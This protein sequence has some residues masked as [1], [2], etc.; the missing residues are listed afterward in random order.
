[1]NKRRK[2]LKRKIISLLINLF[3]WM[4]VAVA[5]YVV[6][7]IFFD[8]PIEYEIRK[9]NSTLT[10]QYDMLSEKF[11]TVNRVLENVEL[12]DRNIYGMLFEAN[13]YNAS[14]KIDTSKWIEKER[15]LNMTNNALAEL[16]LNKLSNVE[17][18]TTKGTERFKQLETTMVSMG[19]NVNFIPAIQPIVNKD[20]TKLAAS[21]GM[22]IQPFFK[23]V[24][25]HQGVD[26]AVPEDTRVYATADGT[27]RSVGQGAT[28]EGLTINIDHGNKYITT[29][30][31]LSK[32]LV[33]KGQQIRRGD[34]IAYSGNSGLSFLPHLHYAISHNGMRIDPINYFFYELTPHDNK[35]LFD[36][37]QI[38][39]QSLD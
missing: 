2:K 21:Y 18:S 29:Y 1:M 13:P 12:R 5:Y 35:Q 14:T 8:T 32:A 10:K 24:A 23:T 7:S 22:R 37:A 17:K 33:N 31:H 39:M 15:L 27:V 19:K 6:F 38:A 11:D 28:G 34:I 16:F 4:G 36:I 26:F 20:F 3:V 30:S 25:S 9:T